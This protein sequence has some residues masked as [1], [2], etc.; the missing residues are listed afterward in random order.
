MFIRTAGQNDLCR[1]EIL[2]RQSCTIPTGRTPAPP[3]LE[4]AIPAVL[5]AKSDLICSESSYVAELN[6]RLIGYGGWS[7]SPPGSADAVSGLVHFR[8]LIV[9]PDQRGR[10]VGRAIFR[11]CMKVAKVAGAVRVQSLSSLN[12]VSFYEKL[13]LRRSKMVTVTL[14]KNQAFPLVVMQASMEKLD[15]ET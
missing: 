6:G 15:A 1:I 12:A 10:G 13:G 14:D 4:E 9:D 5:H 11:R 7:F 8:H 2:L 3:L